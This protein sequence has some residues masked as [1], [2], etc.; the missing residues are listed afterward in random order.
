M[1]R[2]RFK[3]PPRADAAGKRRLV[4]E[5]IHHPGGVAF[6]PPAHHT[7]SPFEQFT[8]VCFAHAVAVTV[9][10]ALAPRARVGGV[11]GAQAH[12][13]RRDALKS[14]ARHRVVLLVLFP[15]C[16]DCAHPVVVV[17]YG[18]DAVDFGKKR[19]VGVSLGVARG[20]NTRLQ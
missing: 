12:R 1:E 16:A 5:P 17:V 6:A 11:V 8:H 2:R 14:V 20:G 7:P 19:R 18:F 3:P 10:V 13:R 15:A 4:V 9:A